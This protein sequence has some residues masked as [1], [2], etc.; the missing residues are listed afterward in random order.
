MHARRTQSAEPGF[1]M[2]EILIVITIIVIIATIAVPNYLNSRIVANETSVLATMKRIAASEFLFRH[3]RLVVQD[4][5]PQFGFLGELSGL[6]PLRSTG[7][8]LEHPVLNPSFGYVDADGITERHG[9]YFRLY[10]PNI[11]GMG[12]PE[13]TATV[14]TV[15]PAYA[16]SYFTCLAWPKTY[17]E[18]GQ[19]TFFVNQQ[20]DVHAT[21]DG[22]YNGRTGKPLPNAG[23]VG[24]APGIITTNSLATGGRVGVDGNRWQ[25]AR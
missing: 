23:L 7:M 18:S 20:G 6:R 22:E 8:Y 1:T 25:L 15:H 13:S 4:D 19:R 9:Y 24:V 5:H 11:V 2:I 14:R 12:V 21:V 10:L 16:S 17:G 3:S